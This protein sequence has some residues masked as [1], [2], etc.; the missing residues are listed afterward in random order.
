MVTFH[1]FG[2]IFVPSF[3]KGKYNYVVEENSVAKP[4]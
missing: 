2:L 3:L 4:G 1:L